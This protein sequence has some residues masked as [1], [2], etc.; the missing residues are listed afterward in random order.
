MSRKVSETPNFKLQP[1]KG[2]GYETTELYEQ[3]NAPQ[4]R[5]TQEMSKRYESTADLQTSPSTLRPSFTTPTATVVQPAKSRAKA[6]ILIGLAATLL[7]C[8][9]VVSLV[10]VILY[11]PQ[12]R[13]FSES[14]DGTDME[15]LLSRIQQLEDQLEAKQTPNQTQAALSSLQ[16]QQESFEATLT[17]QFKNVQNLVQSMSSVQ[18]NSALTLTRLNDNFQDNVLLHALD[19]LTALRVKFDQLSFFDTSVTSQLASMQNLIQTISSVQN[20]HRDGL[21]SP[22]VRTSSESA[23]DLLSRIEQLERRVEQLQA[24]QGTNS[25]LA[26]LTSL[27]ESQESMEASISQLSTGTSVNSQIN[28]IQSLSLQNL[29]EDLNR[30]RSV[31]L[32]QGCIELTSHCTMS[33]GGSSSVYWTSC[34][35]GSLYINP[36]VS[37]QTRTCAMIMQT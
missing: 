26:T 30:L 19:N 12:V 1:N 8:L 14:A 4:S 37:S 20:N 29:R 22:Q 3:V 25:T 15:D 21:Y 24:I 34:S 33:T 35:A 23:A 17:S 6:A 32:Y 18:N 28:S 13:T 31:N 5:P 7:L 36:T 11:S 2:P 27:Q 9:L 10:A 16:E